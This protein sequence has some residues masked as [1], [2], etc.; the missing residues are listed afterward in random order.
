MKE[1][2]SDPGAGDPAGGYSS[3]EAPG[4]EVLGST[5]HFCPRGR[6]CSLYG[7]YPETMGRS[8]LLRLI[9]R[10]YGAWFPSTGHLQDLWPV[11]FFYGPYPETSGRGFLLRLIS[12]NFGP[13]FLFTAY[14]PEL[15]AVVSFYAPYSGTMAHRFLLRALA[16]SSGALSR[17][18]APVQIAGLL[19]PSQAPSPGATRD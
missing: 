9:S 7:S 17:S 4:G 11:V 18:A 2:L 16:R 10:N 12:R 19:F 6:D 15:C 1:S 14:I 3:A 8:F 5:G 13:S